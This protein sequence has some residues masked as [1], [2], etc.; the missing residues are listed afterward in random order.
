MFASL[1]DGCSVGFAT[2]AGAVLCC[3]R[4]MW[5]SSTE[6]RG[7][8]RRNRCFLIAVGSKIVLLVAR[9][10]PGV[11]QFR[12]SCVVKGFNGVEGGKEITSFVSC[13]CAQQMWVGV[14]NC[15]FR[16]WEILKIKRRKGFGERVF[17]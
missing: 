7:G 5:C 9:I 13:L 2:L 14:C 17:F 10:H 1:W 12:N 4:L 11:R 16:V 6:R 8:E 3:S 15:R